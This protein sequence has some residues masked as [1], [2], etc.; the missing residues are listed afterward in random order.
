MDVGEVF[1]HGRLVRCSHYLMCVD[2]VVPVTMFPIQTGLERKV[3]TPPQRRLIV[4][5]LQANPPDLPLV[6]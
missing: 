3:V 4:T 1:L 2:A 6:F 5:I